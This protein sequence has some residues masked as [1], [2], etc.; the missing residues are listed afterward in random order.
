VS[1]LPEEMWFVPARWVVIAVAIARLLLIRGSLAKVGAVGVLWSFAPRKLKMVTVGF[2]AAAT[3]MIAGALAAI[4]L[5]A[6][7]LG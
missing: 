6:L 5:L 4:A 3:I 1:G 7:Q 2:A